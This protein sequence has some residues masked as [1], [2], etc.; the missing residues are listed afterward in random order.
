MKEITVDAIVDNIGVV[1][2]F[3]DEFLDSNDCPM[4]SKIQIDIAIDELFGNICRY[5][6]KDAIG[7]ATI[8]VD[9]QEVPKAIIITFVD[10]GIPYNPLE[11]EDPDC[12]R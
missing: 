2:D 7:Q 11:K 10:S 9:M 6:Y 5:A 8:K 3:I 12:L 1:T 4:K